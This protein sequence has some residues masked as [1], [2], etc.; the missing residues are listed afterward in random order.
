[1]VVVMVVMSFGPAVGIG[2]ADFGFMVH[3]RIRV[4]RSS[5]RWPALIGSKKGSLRLNRCAAHAAKFV[6]S[7]IVVSADWAMTGR[8]RRSSLPAQI[9]FQIT[10]RVLGVGF[11]GQALRSFQRRGDRI[12]ST[13][14]RAHGRREAAKQFFHLGAIGGLRFRGRGGMSGRLLVFIHEINPQDQSTKLRPMNLVTG[15]WNA[16]IP[17][18]SGLILVQRRA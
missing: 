6:A 16:K 12:A 11:C 15:I 14:W 17:Q 3:K 5:A 13:P 8:R 9:L 2:H 4:L 7:A 1:V 10:G 18:G